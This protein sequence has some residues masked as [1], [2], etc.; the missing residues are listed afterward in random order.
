VQNYD[1][2]TLENIKKIIAEHGNITIDGLRNSLQI[3]HRRA[4]RYVDFLVEREQLES[5]TRLGF[6]PTDKF[7][8]ELT[9]DDKTEYQKDTDTI[10]DQRWVIN[11]ERQN[12]LLRDKNN[13]LARTL[14]NAHRDSNNVDTIIEGIIDNIDV[15]NNEWKPTPIAKRNREQIAI[16]QLSDTHFNEKVRPETVKGTNEY[17]WEVAA[18]RL[19]KYA[20]EVKRY[21]EFNNI[22][23]V[24]IAL[25]GDLFNSPRR[26]D[27]IADNQDST[28]VALLTG[29]DLVSKFIVDVCERE[30]GTN[31]RA[32]VYSVFGNESRIKQ[33][34]TSVHWEDSF[35]YLLHKVIS[36]KLSGCQ[37]IHFEE[38][39][40]DHSLVVKDVLGANILLIHG[41]NRTDYRK[42]LEKYTKNPN[43]DERVIIDYMLWGHIHSTKTEERSRR[44]SSLVGNNAYSYHRLG[45]H[46]HAEQNLHILT[47]EA[48]GRLPVL[49][50][51]TINL[52]YT[53][54][55][56]G[57]PLVRDSLYRRDNPSVVDF[58][59]Q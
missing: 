2:Q 58:K 46:G 3:G 6:V 12:Q 5:H 32:N 57:Y 51:I 29:C 21:L 23:Q 1:E 43:L 44:S 55:I 28:C 10:L 22:N 49:Q 59:V 7:T 52:D 15:I 45:L 36:L 18:N 30:D 33:D 9:Q 25:T 19:K 4:K 56:E 48:E 40:L 39:T 37:N 13:R 34:Y 38:P 27:E 26:Y 42:E 14:R 31:R 24:I 50:T 47:K 35:D 53:G 11:V 20:D 41:H 17:N 8:T 16:V 54:D